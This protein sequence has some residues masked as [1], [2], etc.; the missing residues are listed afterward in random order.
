MAATK[1]TQARIKALRPRKTAR[2]VRDSSLRG[3]GVRIHPTGRGCYFI[4]TQVEGKRIWK[5]VGDVADMDVDDAR[6]RARLMLAA[7]RGVAADVEAPLF[8]TVAE[9]VFQ[10]YARNWKPRTLAVN[11]GYYARQILPWFRGRSIAD[12]TAADVRAWFATLHATPV[13]ADRSAPVLSVIM[14]Q[15]EAYGY[16]PEGSNPCKGI[17]RY[18]RKG[19]ERFLCEEEI[20]RLGK[21]LEQHEGDHPAYVAIVRLLLLTGCR[22]REIVT[23]RWREYR[24]GHLHLEDSKTGPR[25]VWLSSPARR[26]LAEQPRTSPWIFPSGMTGNSVH[27]ETVE[28]F[29]RRLRSRAGLQD[30]RLHDLRHTFASIAVMSGENILTVGRLLGHNAPATTLKYIHLADDAAV[31]AAE[32]MGCVLGGPAA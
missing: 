11:R 17:R 4:H 28:F 16:R 6:D 1:L 21:V 24:D 18:R 9:E 5:I 31:E 7:S 27:V 12:I 32:N 14:S 19:R 30:V 23:L 10:R 15:A 3:F 20:R 13:A 26:I 25:M 2:D 22:R 8:E 29:W